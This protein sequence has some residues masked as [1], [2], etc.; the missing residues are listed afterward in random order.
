MMKF[1]PEEFA[2]KKGKGK[3]KGGKIPPQFL[4]KRG[5]KRGRGHAR[6]QAKALSAQAAE[7]NEVNG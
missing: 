1:M 5:K 4:K 2:E 3:G 7:E 6:M